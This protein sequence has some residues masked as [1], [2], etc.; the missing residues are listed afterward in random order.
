MEVDDDPE[1][2]EEEQKFAN[3]SEM[4]M[5]ARTLSDRLQLNVSDLSSGGC[6]G[7]GWWMRDSQ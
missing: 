2:A 1:T 6:D 5:L 3:G 7:C 4:R